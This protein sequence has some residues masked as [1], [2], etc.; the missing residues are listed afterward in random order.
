[1]NR[2]DSAYLLAGGL[3][4]RFGEN[5]ALVSVL[6]ETLIV[7]LARQLASDGIRTKLVVQKVSDYAAWDIPSIEDGVPN[8]GPLAGVLAALRDSNRLGNEWC[9][10]SSCD[11]LDWRTEWRSTLVSAIQSCP[12]AAAAVL[13][14]GEPDDFRPFPGLYRS[15]LWEFGAELWNGGVCSMRE[16]HRRM[17]G[18]VEKCQVVPDL[19]PKSFNTHAELQRLL[20]EKQL[21]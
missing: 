10:I 9:F 16:F 3:S 2:F 5:K 12:N 14:S 15:A 7:R 20:I 17:A 13:F 18:E 1:M 4:S 8:S 21:D 19:L 6:G 11:I